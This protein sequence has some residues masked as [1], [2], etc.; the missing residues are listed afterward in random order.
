MVVRTCKG[1]LKSDGK[2]KNESKSVKR[3][4]EVIFW[5]SSAGGEM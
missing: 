1:I 3:P 4:T 2:G 5:F